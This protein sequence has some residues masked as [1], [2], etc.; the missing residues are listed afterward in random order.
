[1]CT[2]RLHQVVAP[3]GP[4]AVSVADVEGNRHQVS[5]LALDGPA[6]EPGD[7][8]VVHS[9]YAIDRVGPTEAEAVV[10]ELRAAGVVERGRD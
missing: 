2:S 9:G 6:P 1:M 4:R 7:W 10:A 5:L 8:V 3:A